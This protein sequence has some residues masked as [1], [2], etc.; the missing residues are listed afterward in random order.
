M[1]LYQKVDELKNA[2]INDE[3]IIKLQEAEKKMNES[4]EVQ[5]LSYKKDIAISNYSD[6][7]NHFSKDSEEIKQYQKEL[8]LA[9]KALD[10]HPL[11]KDYL[12]CYI[13]VRDLYNEINDILFSNLRENLRSH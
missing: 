8:H 7:L 1:E 6:A 11:V 13:K 5:I 3:R 9:K 2:L 10:E 4:K 12:S